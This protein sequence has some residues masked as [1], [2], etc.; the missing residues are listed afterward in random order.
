MPPNL[1]TFDTGKFSLGKNV[2]TFEEYIPL[3]TLQFYDLTVRTWW[4]NPPPLLRNVQTKFWKKTFVIFQ[5]PPPTF[6]QCPKFG[7]FFF[8]KASLNI[9]L[10][11]ILSL[12]KLPLNFTCDD[13]SG[14][15]CSWK[16]MFWCCWKLARLLGRWCGGSWSVKLLRLGFV[17]RYSSST[18]FVDI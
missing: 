14:Q 6:G 5:T 3:I 11:E 17:C 15:S 13:W 10:I 18:K 9:F 8:L 7:S 1:L 2:S 16:L 4:Q 12:V